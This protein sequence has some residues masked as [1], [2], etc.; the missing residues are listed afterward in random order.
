MRE[1]ATPGRA[2][3]SKE[4]L[5][6]P[7]P[8]VPDQ[9]GR[10]SLP[11]EPPKPL[12]AGYL[13]V[14]VWEGEGGGWDGV[15]ERWGEWEGVCGVEY[16]GGHL[17]PRHLCDSE[18]R[19]SPTRKN[20]GAKKRM[21][22]DQSERACTAGRRDRGP[23]PARW[24]L[25]DRAPVA[26]TRGAIAPQV[27]RNYRGARRCAPWNPPTPDPPAYPLP[28]REA[29]AHF[30]KP[31]RRRLGLNFETHPGWRG[32]G[33]GRVREERMAAL[34]V[35]QAGAHSFNFRRIHIRPLCNALSSMAGASFKRRSILLWR[36]SHT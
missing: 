6:P 27:Y 21:Y 16:L 33:G 5:R 24:I 11:P 29:D 8:T 28:I 15:A 1:H 19:D 10:R 25:V 20:G 2:K 36:S 26:F 34:G 13:R 4:K 3:R 18:P 30:T 14:S 22:T 9:P 7:A 32:G 35:W 31:P 17:I 12:I 23:R